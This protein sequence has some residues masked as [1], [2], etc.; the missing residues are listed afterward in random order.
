MGCVG[1]WSLHPV[2]IDIAKKVFSPDP[3]EVAFAKKVIEAIPDGRG[4]HMIDGKMQ[5]DATWKQCKVM[6]DL[7]EMLAA[8]GPR[9]GGGVRARA[10]AA[11]G[12]APHEVL[13][14]RVARDPR[15]RASPSPTSAS[16]P[17][18]E[19]ARAVAE[20]IGGPVV[21]KSQVL[22]GG[23]MKAGG[24]QVRRHARGG[25]SSTPTTSSQLEIGGHMPRGV[26]VDAK[27]EVKQEYYAGVVWD[28]MRK[29]PVLIFSDMGG[30][31]IEEVAEEQPDHVGRGHFSTILPFMD[32]MAKDVI[33]S[34]G[35]TGRRST[36]SR[37]SSPGSRG[38]SSSTT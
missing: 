21:I 6:V 26:L 7:A 19:E 2:Q 16:P 37:R 28:G 1:A 11:V 4:V 33:A 9:A 23:R 32:F 15:A 17:T 22:T 13:R 5:D 35:V 27:A 29:Q 30:I 31:D 12:S 10:S 38:C 34:T 18:A 3:E 14:I 20:R 25:R 8:Q 36:G 24:V